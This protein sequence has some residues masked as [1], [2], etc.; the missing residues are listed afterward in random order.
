MKFKS[1]LYVGLI[2]FILIINMYFFK[3]IFYK[4]FFCKLIKIKLG[5]FKKIMN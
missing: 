1:I 5:F 2:L 4:V 3:K